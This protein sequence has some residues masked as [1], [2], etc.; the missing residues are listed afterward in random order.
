[1][2][3]DFNLLPG[4]ARLWIYQ[5]DRKFSAADESVIREEAL[6]FCEQ[7]EAHG[8]PLKTSYRIEHDQFLVLAVDE[9]FSGVSGC[10][11]DGS[12]RMLKSVQDQT[13][14]DFFDR[15]KAAFLVNGLVELIPVAELKKA[16]ASGTLRPASLAFN[17]H[18]TTKGDW[19]KNWITP[20][21]KTWLTRF[22][23]KT[24]IA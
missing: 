15:S 7:W 4:H 3:I 23:P 21:E 8:H 12:V 14:I 2:Y 16:F 6:S 1:M 18:A 17:S 19:E 24:S 5:A 13:G 10:S 22:L 11:I 20:A 9:D